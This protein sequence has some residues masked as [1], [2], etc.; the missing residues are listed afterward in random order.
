MKKYS[1]ILSDLEFQ[2]FIE[3]INKN[4]FNGELTEI[5]EV[6]YAYKK[7]WENQFFNTTLFTAFWWEKYHKNIDFDL[8][9]H[10]IYTKLSHKIEQIDFFSQKINNVYTQDKQDKI[11]VKFL[12]KQFSYVKNTL[13][14]AQ[15]WL[16][17]EIQKAGGKY[18]ISSSQ[19]KKNIQNIKKLEKKNFGWEI[20]SKPDEVIKCFEFLQ[21]KSYKKSLKNSPDFEYFLE[22]IKN[23]LPENYSAGEKK[24]TRKKIF[25]WIF[26]T[27]IQR[28][29]YCEIFDLIFEIYGLPQRT[30]IT[31]VWSIYDGEKFLEIP[32]KKSYETKTLK[33]VLKLSLHEIMAHCVNLEN[34]KR[35]L[36]EFRWAH[37]LEKE[38]W[39]AVLLEK[40]FEGI[41]ISN[42]WIIASLPTLL[43]WEICETQEF[44]QFLQLNYSE[45][46]KA[47]LRFKR[48]YSSDFS[49]VQ[50]KDTS[51]SRGILK[52]VQYIQEK[53]NFQDLFLWKVSFDEIKFLKKIDILDE[54]KP[55]IQPLF[56][57]EFIYFYVK[58]IS[59]ET[60]LEKFF[61]YMEEKYFFMD[62][63]YLKKYYQKKST[64]K[65][66]YKISHILQKY[67]PDLDI[68]Y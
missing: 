54:N 51:Y 56:I 47:F 52:T 55:M 29:D 15:Y 59:E 58:N 14:I 18:K 48:N 34:T 25:P 40:V 49:G 53:K 57:A 4:I 1:T 42:I 8:L 45:P 31:N 63:K 36:G 50:H 21:K 20:H 17:F 16:A 6:T 9:Y 27:Q 67:I 43:M 65:N 5:I 23:I 38:E 7:I 12:E 30:K 41:H 35:R 24:F 10:K 64:K 46:N 13:L 37:N 11:R 62:T 33:S 39:L 3:E 68:Q 66:I 44:K 22:K 28:E 2:L 32:N 19:V 61:V 26:Q 60:S